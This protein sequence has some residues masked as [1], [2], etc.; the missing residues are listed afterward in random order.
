MYNTFGIHRA[1]PAK[2]KN[3][4][5][6]TLFFQVEQELNHSE[7]I[8]IKTEFLTKCD[9]QIKMFLGFGRRAGQKIYPE[10]SLD[11][12]PFNKRTS[13]AI[14]KW[15][16]SRFANTLPGFLRKRIRKVLKS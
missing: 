9:E 4:T 6:K 8:L 11:T 15:L 12:M 16:L 3:F 5:R 2:N 7:P 13:S 14:I 1:K 10:T